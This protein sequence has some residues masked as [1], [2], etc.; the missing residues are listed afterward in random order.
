VT[1]RD[2]SNREDG[3]PRYALYFAPPP[4]SAW[5]DLGCRWLGRDPES[6]AARPRPALNGWSQQRLDAITREPAGYGFHA[7]LKAPFRLAGG[8]TEDAL[9]QAVHEVARHRPAFALPPLRPAALASFVALVLPA[10]SPPMQALAADCVRGFDEFRA[11]LTTAERDHRRA[12]GLTA[13]QEA[14]LARWG[15]PYVLDDWQFHMTLTSQVNDAVERGRLIADLADLFAPLQ[16]EPVPV[17]DVCVFRQ[18]GRREPFRLI[19]RA[20]LQG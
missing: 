13:R 8:I 17:Q 2:D 1:D 3:Q 16:T 9:L 15:Y 18:A 10:P 20:A 19:A 14:Y 5:W 7:T 11:P 12:G 6:G 4:L